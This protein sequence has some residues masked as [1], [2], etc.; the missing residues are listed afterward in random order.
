MKHFVRIMTTAQK[1][2]PYPHGIDLQLDWGTYATIKMFQSYVLIQSLTA[3][4]EN[5]AD[6]C[7]QSRT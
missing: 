7:I 2:L 3:R 1:N 5:R 4:A 6:T